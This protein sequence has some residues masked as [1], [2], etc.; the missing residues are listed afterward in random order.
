VSKDRLLTAAIELIAER[1]EAKLRLA[2]VAERAG[3][4]IG[5]VQHHFRSRERL[6]AHAQVE[7][8]IQPARRDIT[9]IRKLLENAE[10]ADEVRV[11]LAAVTRSVVDRARSE[12]RMARL[13]SLSAVHGRP[14]ARAV[15][16][17]EVSRLTE[18]LADAIRG[19]QTKGFFR[20]D[21]DPTAIS[22]FVQAY[23]L[24]MTI[25]DMVEPASGDET[26]A[27][28]IDLFT[29]SLLVEPPT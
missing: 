19:S 13:S 23:A 29:T 4:S 12:Q 20:Q 25:A 21:I 8:F 2:D 26:L 18:E 14:D 24:G 5:A 7:R 9:A 27:S 22:V 6:V 17:A 15:M 28:V 16:T 1:G 3:T 10:T 11:A